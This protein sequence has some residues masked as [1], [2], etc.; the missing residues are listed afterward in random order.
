MCDCF[1]TPFFTWR[2]GNGTAVHVGVHELLYRELIALLDSTAKSLEF[3]GAHI[4]KVHRL[5]RE[6]LIRVWANLGD[7]SCCCQ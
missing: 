4:S 5:R 6:V 7:L 1:R 3:M 2:L